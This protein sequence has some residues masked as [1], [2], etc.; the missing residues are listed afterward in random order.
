M[1]VKE[2]ALP[3]VLLVQP[4]VFRDERGTF[5]ETWRRDA[6]AEAGIPP[7]LRQ[8]NA[9]TSRM[10]V[11]RGLHFQFPE[12][13]GKLVMTLFGAVFDVAL[14]VRPGSPTFGRWIGET[15]SAENGTQLW[16][17]EGFAHGYATIS[18]VA[19]FA[20]KCTRVYDP[21]ADRA[22]RYD[23]PELGIPWPVRD[24]IVSTKDAG[25][26]SLRDLPGEHL[27]PFRPS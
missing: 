16:I 11:I 13:Q 26:P 20:Y 14:D 3:G 15:L 17:P 5:Q 6:Y 8:D 1:F 7:Y 21:T 2:T 24:P 19:V 27:P 10:G 4:K 18:E 22:I 9:A 25:A 12:P 23:D